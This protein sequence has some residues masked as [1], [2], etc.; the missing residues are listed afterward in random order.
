[1]PEVENEGQALGHPGLLQT[2]R[3]FPKIKA[4]IS[5]QHRLSRRALSPRPLSP[6]V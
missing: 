6:R 4:L 1:M 5:L 2:H 3:D